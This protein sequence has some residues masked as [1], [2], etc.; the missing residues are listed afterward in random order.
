VFFGPG[1]GAPPRHRVDAPDGEYQ[2]LYV[3]LSYEGALVET[4]LRNPRRRTVDLVDLE[5]RRMA[6]LTNDTPL[7]LVEA[8]GAGLSRLGT[9]AALST[10]GYHASRAWALALWRHEA[11]PDGLVYA[12]RHNP[13]LLCAAVYDR[14]QA[15]FTVAATQPLLEDETRLHAVFAAHGKSI[16]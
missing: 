5:T 9:T 1:R 4:L 11:R 12:S 6:V 10:G 7:R 2:V 16:G 14:P 8:H 15:I 3:A 13:G